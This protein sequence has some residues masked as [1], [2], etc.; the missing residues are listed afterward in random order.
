[1]AAAFSLVML[2]SAALATPI[3]SKNSATTYEE[4]GFERVSRIPANGRTYHRD[5]AGSLN[6][7]LLYPPESP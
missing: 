6:R 3:R 5:G 4:A 1:M 2:A 7:L